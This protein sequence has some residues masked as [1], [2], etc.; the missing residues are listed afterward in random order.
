MLGLNAEEVSF[1]G[2]TANAV[3][4]WPRT[5]AMD[6]TMNLVRGEIPPCDESG[7][8]CS[9]VHAGVAASLEPLPSPTYVGAAV[10]VDLVGSCTRRDGHALDLGLEPSHSR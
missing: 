2:A 10:G 1:S 7:S 3:S 5:H 8:R 4:R 9:A 6:A